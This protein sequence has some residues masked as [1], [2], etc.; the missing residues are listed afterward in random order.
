[1]HFQYTPYI[2]PLLAAAAILIWVA[3]YAWRHRAVPSAIPLAWLALAITEW[4][5][6][7]ALEIAGADLPT[8][9][10]WGKIQYIGITGTPFLWLIF[11]L[12]H[13]G[14]GRWLT[15]RRLAWLAVIP[16]ITLLLVFTTETHGLIW[17]KIRIKQVGDFSALDVS[18]GFWFWINFAYA[19]IL[20]LAGTVIILRSI[21]RRQGLYRGQTVTLL[22]GVLVPWIGNAIYLSG[23]SPIPH[24]DLTPFSFTITILALTWGIFGFELV[25]LAPVARDLIV[26]EMKDGMIVLDAQGRIADINHAAQEMINLSSPAQ[27]IGQSITDILNPW[28]HLVER[29][30]DVLEAQDEISLGEGEGQ[31][32]YE[33]RVSPLYDRR[34][35]FIG[36]VI[37]ARNVT[38]RKHVDDQ[39]R[40]LARAVEASPASIVITDA[41][42]SI[43]YVNPKFTQVTGY[44]LAEAIGQ[45]PRILKT[46][47]TPPEV[48][49]QLWET[50]R[51]GQEW[52]G[53]FCNR[54][55]NGELFWESASISPLT[56][57]NG[58]I[59]HYVAVKEDITERKRIGDKLEESE[60]RYRQ[61]VESASDIIYRT[62][63]H[64]RFTYVNPPTLRLMGLKSSAD[65]LGRHY[66]E[67]AAPAFRHKL[68][69]FYDRQFLA[70]EANT[71]HEFAV[72]STDGREIWLGQNVQI[73]KEGDQI[74][75]FQAVA[76][77]ITEIKRVQNALAIARDQALEANRLKSQLLARVSHE[78]RTPLGG[79]LGYA[80]LLNDNAFG[81]L[82]EKQKQAIT[83]I[84]DSTNYLTIMVNAL[85]DEA[86]LEAN[87]IELC[88]EDVSPSALL[89]TVETGMAALA[90]NK[91][92]TF[93]VTLAPDTPATVHG[94][95]RR[96]Q[97]ILTNLTANAIKFTKAGEVRVHFYR[98]DPAHWAMQVSDTGA[99][100]PA[101]AQAYIFEPFRQAD[102]SITYENRGSGLGLS[103][104]K[105]LVELMGGHITLNSAIG[106]GSVFTV[107][108]PLQNNTGG[109]TL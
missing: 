35:R 105:Q 1:M 38:D 82:N 34:Q 108:L 94:D 107:V 76:R 25:D 100:I 23:F 58:T 18:Y 47:Q 26:E 83:Q 32:W 98:P 71:Y 17:Q 2:L 55:K 33:L 92:L 30:Q 80:E 78:L 24:L 104:T 10:L 63:E 96:L 29:Y 5:V 22:I 90:H 91:G 97:Q 52:S 84:I 106:Q 43:Q 74:I 88:W 42:G 8:K 67:L 79:V 53:E 62:D 66:L 20:L 99:G 44:T 65:M 19:Y 9:L 73:L 103:I 39:L 75:G 37:M 45:N 21:G 16:F 49:R 41:K 51:Q 54:K 81:S 69:R 87:M 95:E 28:P 13:A 70:Q 7:Y 14:Q 102:S 109:E 46:D 50:L 4:S 64:G 101:A 15:T 89:Q 31:S 56:D 93:T 40:Q 86:Q 59:T 48:H 12:T 68:K 61:L 72:I 3:V 77:D 36:R 11:A 27:A 57:A 6:G 85:L 60:A